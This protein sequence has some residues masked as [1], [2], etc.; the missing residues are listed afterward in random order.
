MAK[1]KKCSTIRKCTSFFN[2]MCQMFL[3]SFSL[4]LQ[5]T[6]HHTPPH[7]FHLGIT[8]SLCFRLLCGTGLGV[9]PSIL[10]LW[11]NMIVCL[12][13]FEIE[14]G[15]QRELFGFHC[16]YYAAYK[17][18]FLFFSSSHKAYFIASRFCLSGGVEGLAS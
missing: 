7:L 17:T 8:Q 5:Y 16:S 9:A 10:A 11:G 12:I 14:D 18:C 4:F 13:R 3:T 2:K 6:C 15:V 1:K